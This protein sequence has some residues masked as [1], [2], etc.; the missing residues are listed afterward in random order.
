MEMTRQ[1]I[2]MAQPKDVTVEAELGKIIGVEDDIV[3][4]ES[5]LADPDE[6]VK[7]CAELSLDCFAPA[8]GT[9]A[10]GPE[11]SEGGPHARAAVTTIS[12][13]SSPARSA[14]TQARWGQFSSPPIHAHQTASIS[15]FIDMSLR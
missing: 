14:P 8:I 1:V 3:S 2:G 5:S 15:A 12:T 13:R 11:P 9:A 7:F 4:D 6:A 10:R